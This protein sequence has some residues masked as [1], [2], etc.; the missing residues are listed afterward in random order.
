MSQKPPKKEANIGAFFRITDILC[1]IAGGAIAHAIRFDELILPNKYFF[2][3]VAL[4]F[5]TVNVF[6]AL[7]VYK[8]WRGK[9]LFTELAL[10]TASW[11]AVILTIST[12]TFIT[13]TGAEYSR[14][15]AAWTFGITYFIFVSYRIVSRYI[16]RHLQKSGYNQ[17]QV[18]II[19]AGHLGQRASLSMQQQ[20]WAGLIPIAFFDDARHG[21]TYNGIQVEG[22]TKDVIAFIENKRKTNP[23]DQVWI[24]LPLRA[25]Q[26]IE[27][28]ERSLQDTA[29]KVYFIPD[30]FGFN[31]ASYTVDEMVGL[32]VMNMSAP[33]ISSWSATLKRT[34]DLIVSTIALLLLSPLFLTTAILIKKD[35]PGPVFFK[36]RRYGLD[37][38]EILVWKFRSMTTTDNGE[39]VKQ[40]GRNDA[41]VTKIGAFLRKSSI[42]ELPQLINVL[43]GSMSLVGPRPHAVAHNE[44]Y[45]TK[46][47]GYMSR[48]QM[49]P[50]ITG[51][52]QV[53]GSRGE[54]AEVKDMQERIRYDLEYIKNWSIPLDIRIILMTFKTVLN[55]KDTY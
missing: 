7:S 44:F 40:A 12:L 24:A 23:V 53:N 41:R 32:P 27:D 30:L 29:T 28:L 5:L 16:I 42:D 6:S 10:L 45:R 20:S 19:G 39:N 26:V 1:I 13:K 31:L 3:T 54:T 33:P 14:E 50:G 15:W 34:E 25:Q 22:S 48:H 55:T 38:R 47:Q 21:M 17:K 11:L 35:S 52:A 49:R 43:L 9:S 8:G 51:W 4:I 18:I 36:Q 2:F 46:V 37:G